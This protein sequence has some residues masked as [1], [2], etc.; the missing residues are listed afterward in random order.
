M[1][2]LKKGLKAILEKSPDDIVFLSALRTPVTRSFKGKLANAHAE[3]LLATV[4]QATKAQLPTLDLSEVSDVAVGTVLSELGGQKAGRAA[5]LHAG[6]PDS[7]AI[8]TVNRACSSGLQAVT[9]VAEAIAAGRMDMGIG[10]GM[11]SMTRNYGSKAIPN[12]V[13]EELR[14][15]SV[16]A[17]RDCLL[18]MG[19]TSEN[20][21][22][23]YGISRTDQ[24]AFALAS[25]AKATKAQAEGRFKNE[26]IPVELVSETGDAITVTQDDGIRPNASLEQLAKLKPAFL[27]DGAS[28]AGNSSQISDGASVVLMARRSTATRLGLSDYILGKW[29]RS[30]VA[31]VA[32]DEMGVGPAV[33]IPKMLESAGILASDV[34]VWEINEAF[35][36]QALYCVDKLGIDMNKVNPNGGAIALGHPLGATGARQLTTLLHELKRSGQPVGVV[37]MC[38]GTGMGK[39][40]LI[41]SE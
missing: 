34:G 40:A 14:E 18:P 41:I 13:W 4:L 23:R 6:Y 9:N 27:P 28:T 22:Q 21:A 12:I 35:A 17:A 10:G 31:G 29:A 32:P 7:A 8:Y 37:S 25:H 2:H 33:V 26:I 39:S 1:A 38:I 5:L 30:A 24:D 36:S 19:I 3:Q 20:V 16:Q 15:S 11:E